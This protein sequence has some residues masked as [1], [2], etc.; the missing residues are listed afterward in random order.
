MRTLA[1]TFLLLFSWVSAKAQVYVNPV[2]DRT[3]VPSLHIDKIEMTKAATVIHCTYFAVAGS[4]ANISRDVYLQDEKTRKK[5]PL[6]KCDGFPFGPE[7]KSFLF[8][9]KYEVSFYFSPMKMQGKF[10]FI[11][12]PNEQAFNVYGI[13][14]NNQYVKQYNES[15]IKRFSNMASFYESSGDINNAIQNKEEEIKATQYVNG[16]KSEAYLVSLFSLAIM[17]DKYE[18]YGDAVKEME[19]LAK[20][21]AEIWGTNDWQYALQLRTFGQ[22]YS[23]AKMSEQAIK[24]Y[25]ESI[26]LYEK[27][28]IVDDQYILALSFLSNEYQSIEKEDEALI[29]Q[30]KVIQ[31]RKKLGNSEKYLHELEMMLISGRSNDRILIVEKELKDLPAFVDTISMAYTNMLK[32]MVVAYEIIR[33]DYEK[34][35]YYCDRSL[36]ILKLNESE[37]ILRIAEMLGRKSRYLCWLNLYKE[38]IETG[39]N[40]KMIFDTYDVK[41][42]IYITILQ[43]L[44]RCY[45]EAYDY[46]KSDSYLKQME[47]LCKEKKD[48][49]SL[50]EAYNSIGNN[51]KYSEQLDKAEQYLIKAIEVLNAHDDARQYIIDVIEQTGNREIDNPSTLASIQYRIDIDKWGFNGELA[52]IYQ[53]QGKMSNAIA[54]EIDNEEILK[55]IGDE[56][57]YVMHL[58]ALAHYYIEDKQYDIAQK[59]IDQILLLDKGNNYMILPKS[60]FFMAIIAKESGKLNEAIQYFEKAAKLSKLSNNLNE[61][62]FI[63]AG[64]SGLYC[65]KG[66]YDKAEE[67]LS[68]VLGLVQ[69]TIMNDI[70]GMKSNQKQRLWDKY[71]LFF[72]KY[73]DIVEKAGWNPVNNSKLFDFTLFSKSLLLDSDSS[74]KQTSQKRMSI[75]W[76]DIQKSLSD[77]DIAI[78]FVSIVDSLYYSTYYALVI[79]KSCDYPN[80]ITLYKDSDFEKKI[81]NRHKFVIDVV[82]DLVWKP[83]L[84][85]YVPKNIFFSPDGI[86][87]RVPIEYSN[88]DGIGEMNDKYNMFRL[89]STK[90]IVFNKQKDTIKKAALFG[91]LDYNGI[92][93]NADIGDN[94]TNLMRS[95]NERGG[96]EP[97]Y[98]TYEEITE[99]GNILKSN[100]VATTIY[101]EDCGTEEIFKNLS[102]KNVNVL[103][104]S[105]HGMYVNPGDA[106]QKKNTNNFD[107]LELISNEKDPVKEDKVMT[108]SFLIMSGGNKTI[109][110]KSIVQGTEDGIL[111]ASEI[112]H[113]DLQKLDLVVLSAC[114]TALGDINYSGIYG[115]QRG[116]KKAGAKTILMSLDKVDD[117]ATRLLMVEFYRNLMSGKTKHQSLKNA[118]HYLRQVDNG[119]YD[120]PE[121][122][123][124]FIM[125][126]GLN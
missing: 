13:D 33:E 117:E 10:D 124:S 26:A 116:F 22:F 119:K 125:L 100:N 39:E 54:K 19:L 85:Q 102:G 69:N 50:A 71:E 94:S 114:E 37:N 63:Q 118:L 108:H 27:L 92:S 9:E 113:M 16:V 40:A 123:A 36:S 83:I 30:N 20:L 91:G 59:S 29:F 15:D 21:Q 24:K 104:L 89:S 5:Y 1:Y 96:F 42:D 6:I 93:N 122:W 67:K 31:A 107:F 58:G 76:R 97:L 25:K 28:N 84:R 99:I 23:H 47:E 115:L 35:S 43:D 51:Y 95:I 4:W 79:D 56:Q 61:Q 7:R 126:D 34:A 52:S 45:L 44:A 105:T 78:E 112:S 90:E 17:H 87:H 38:S 46:E 48:W 55:Q 18:L 72:V 49:L 62:F 60:Y 80:I 88:V 73:R 32:A 66:L 121:Y 106:E 120:K 68:E 70:T 8:D 110:R 12:N 57:M 65:D 109:Q 11:E 53:K 77:D 41:P 111:T 75:K 98:G 64:L 103:H 101:A 14:I 2:F 86:L 3:D 81:Q 82:G 74:D